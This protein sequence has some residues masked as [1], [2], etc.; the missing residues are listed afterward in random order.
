M[1]TFTL[2]QKWV[3]TGCTLTLKKERANKF[4]CELSMGEHKSTIEIHKT[5]APGKTTQYIKGCIACGMSSIYCD[6]ENWEKAKFWQARLTDHK[7]WKKGDL[8]P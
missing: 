2:A 3:P 5:T 1:T 7:S 6:M 4:L 8:T